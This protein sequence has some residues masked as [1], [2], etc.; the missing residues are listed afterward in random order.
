MSRKRAAAGLAGL[1]VIVALSAG[2]S[3]ATAEAAG[4][5]KAANRAQAVKFAECM[6]NN[7]VR[8][9]PDPDAS[10]S[11]TIDAVLN[12]SSID[13]DSSVWKQ[14]IGACEDLQPAGFT[15]TKRTAA[16]QEAAIEFARCVRENGVSDFPDPTPDSPLVDTNR[17]P[18]IAGG[19]SMS[20]LHAAMKT[21]GVT[22]GA[23]AGVT[24]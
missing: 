20:A 21:C 5:G 4:D 15:G 23:R 10:G 24:K 9:F 18:S 3:N 14:A 11:L 17:I 19:G 1:A 12:G 7:G 22:F 2:C 13:S 16:Q 8:A 6:R